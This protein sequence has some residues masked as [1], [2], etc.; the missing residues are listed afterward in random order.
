VYWLPKSR[1]TIEE[2]STI[3]LCR[4]WVVDQESKGV[5]LIWG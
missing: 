2:V 4:V 1:M 5:R 3:Y